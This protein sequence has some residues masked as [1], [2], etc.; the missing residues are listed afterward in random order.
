MLVLRVLNGFLIVYLMIL[1][2]RIILTWF[3]GSF[4]GKA[5]ELLKQATDPY[6]EIFSRITFL[7]QGMFDFTP[8]AGI[9]VLVVA[10]DLVNVLLVYERITIGLLLASIISALWGGLSFILLLFLVLGVVQI[11]ST[12]FSRN[13]ES[14]LLRMI[15]LMFQPIID[16][17]ARLLRPR[18]ELS[19]NQYLYIT[20]G[21]I[22]FIRLLGGIVLSRLIEL[23]YTLPV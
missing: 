17:V 22:F 15:K 20:L 21:L 5:G 2:I 8:L 11:V 12:L 9:L 10:L 23:L 13:S 3:K 19:Y 1:S 16:L 7:K 6:L 18:R 14:P 4:Q